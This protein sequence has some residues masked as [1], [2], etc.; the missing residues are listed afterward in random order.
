MQ[1]S[2]RGLMLIKAEEGVK[3]TAYWDVSGWAIGYGHH[4]PEVTENMTITLE[5]ADALLRADVAARAAQIAPLLKVRLN[6]N[7]IDAIMDFV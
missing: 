3:L 4:G 1:I 5:Q 2:E 7:Q 6:Q